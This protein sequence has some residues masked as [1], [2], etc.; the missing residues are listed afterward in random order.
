MDITYLDQEAVLNIVDVATKFSADDFLSN[1]STSLV[2][3]VFV[4]GWPSMCTNL[5]D[6][7]CTVRGSCF[8]D[9]F[10]T[11]ADEAMIDI[12]RTGIKASSRL[13]IDEK[14]H[15]PLKNTFRKAKRSME[16]YIP[17]AGILA[18]WVQAMNDILETERIVPSALVI[19]VFTSTRVFKKL[20]D[21]KPTN[22]H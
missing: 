1:A 17:N 2:W 20:R 21:P 9:D 7:I 16:N 22:R 19:R 10:Y 6:K 12:A 3:A 5:H 8:G 11:I 13:G 18:R 14:F 15:R 4:G